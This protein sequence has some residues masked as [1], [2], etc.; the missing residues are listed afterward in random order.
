M[1]IQTR[2]GGRI[3]A[4]TVAAALF[5]LAACDRSGEQPTAGERVGSAVT[6][7]GQ[8]TESA[9]N[10]IRQ[11]VAEAREDATRATAD[12][13]ERAA[14]AAE[15]VTDKLQDATITAAVNAELA[16]DAKLSALKIDVDTI[17][18]KVSLKGTAPDAEARARAGRLA[19]GVQ[20]VTGVDNRLD[21]RS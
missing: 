13:K 12:L 15:T 2:I 7:A 11:E 10:G 5:S 1:I 4:I 8:T 18:G 20:G 6:L 16:K 3:T 14:V 19:S 17:S 9:R 21:V